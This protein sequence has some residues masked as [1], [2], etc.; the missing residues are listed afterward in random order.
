MPGRAVEAH[1][2]AFAFVR[3]ELRDLVRKRG[4]ILGAHGRLGLLE[5]SADVAEIGHAR[6]VDDGHAS[7][8]AFDGRLA[9]FMRGKALAA[10]GEVRRAGEAAQFARG[11]CEMNDGAGRRGRSA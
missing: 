8:G 9:A 7:G 5:S 11:V 1:L 4:F 6:P 10:E 3:A 2:A